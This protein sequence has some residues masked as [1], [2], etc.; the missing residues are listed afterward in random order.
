MSTS[1]FLDKYF[2]CKLPLFPD[3]FFLMVVLCFFS[4]GIDSM[5]QDLQRYV[6]Q[7]RE[8]EIEKRGGNINSP[9]LGNENAMGGHSY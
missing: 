4:L 3:F 1:A 6:T 7:L 5:P 8:I 2:E 9:L